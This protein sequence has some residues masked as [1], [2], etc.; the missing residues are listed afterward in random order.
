MAERRFA[1]LASPFAVPLVGTRLI[2]AGAGTGKT[3]TLAALVLRLILEQD[4]PIGRILVVTYT[5]AATGELAARIRKRL[6][7]A[8]AAFERGAAEEAFLAELLARHEAG[9]AKALLRLAIESFDE[10]AIFT[11]HGFCQR[12]L[13]ECA[14]EAGHA[15]ERELAPEPG[16]FLEAAARDAWRR[17]MAAASPAWAQWLIDAFGGPAGLARRVRPYLGHLQAR[18]AAPEDL[19]VAAEHDFAVAHAAALA[20]W[21]REAV[22]ARLLAAKLHKGSYKP[23]KLSLCAIALDRWFAGPPRLPLPDGAERFGAAK[24]AAKLNKGA[25]PPAH[26]FFAAMQT[27]L[28]AASRLAQDFDAAVR[29][30]AHDFLVA[31]R[32]DVAARKRSAGQQSFDDLLA[33]L[34]AALRG[35]GGPALVAGLRARYH[36]ALVDEFQDTDLQQ[37]DIFTAAFGDGERPLVLVGDPKQAIYGFRGADVFAYLAARQRASD[38]YALVA[39]RRSDPPLIVA[40]NALFAGPNPFLLDELPFEPAQPADM[41]RTP[42]HIE[43]DVP[44][45][46]LWTL[47]PPAPDARFSKEDAQARA[48][49]ATANDI[50]RLLTLAAQGKARIGERPLG[51]GDIAVLVRKRHQGDMVRDALARRGIAS[52]SMGGG[53]VWQ[54]KAAEDIERLLLAVAAPGRAGLVRAALATALMGCTAADIAA[55]SAD[56]RAWNARVEAFHDDQEE[57]RERGF[58]AMWR[59]LLRREGVIVRVMARPDGERR[60]TDYRH[61]AELLQAAEHAGARD[62]TALARHIARARAEAEGEESQLRLESDAH[63]VHIVTIHAA[64]GLQYPV[65]YCPFLWEGPKE[66]STSDWP[67]LAHADGAAQ[68]DFGSEQIAALAAAARREAA[69]EEVRLAYVALTRAEHRCVVIWAHANQSERSPLAW[70]LFGASA[71]VADAPPPRFA[72]QP[73]PEAGEAVA[74]LPAGA[75]PVLAARPFAATVPAPWRVWSFSALAARLDAAEAPDRDAVAVAVPPAPTFVAPYAS[76]HAFPRG[77]RAG[78]CLHALFERVDFQQP[79]TTGP[80]AAAVL[81][82]FGFATEW[83]PVLEKLVADVVAAP[84]DADGLR[85]SAVPRAA[86]LVELEFAFPLGSAAAQAGYMKGFID[87]V[88]RHGGRWYIVDWKSNALDDYGPEGLAAAMRAHRYDMQAHIYAAALRRALMSREPGLDWAAAFGGVFHL[89]LRGMRPDA[90]AGVHWLRPDDAEIAQWLP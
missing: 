13:A 59:R 85:L 10:A 11:I 63:L 40:V 21:D 5:R 50:A 2:E 89:F 23:E 6:V 72:A 3:W 88:F 39:N 68:L 83:R 82:E 20:S 42:C 71:A 65:V 67:L 56:E 31:A 46:A 90:P 74:P 30:F 16:A 78:S 70:L 45:L 26:P 58:M 47:A 79:E 62:A 43:D 84:L 60:L 38:G 34:A 49:A 9:R 41:T 12:V 66:D 15:F 27:L 14:F 51:G 33:D 24:I 4:M 69:A 52:I 44:S 54:S 73:A 57:L 37:L 61:L 81:A 7:E 32:A 55:L 35:P 28:D 86:R 8:L 17:A 22:L 1:P 18:L 19:R 53:S 48:V 76:I 80:H 64:K 25:A 36:A 87:L 29:R 77:T 75:T